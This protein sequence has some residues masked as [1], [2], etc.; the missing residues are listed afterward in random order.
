MWILRRSHGD[1]RGAVDRGHNLPGSRVLEPDSKRVSY[2]QR[3]MDQPLYEL[4]RDRR[5]AVL[6]ALPEA[7]SHRS[8]N[9]LAAHVRTNHVHAIV[10]GEA[11]PERIMNDFKSYDSRRLSRLNPEEGERKR[12]ARHGST[13]WLFEKRAGIGSHSLRGR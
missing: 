5:S 13:R 8:W 12:W 11:P 9:L 10:E 4:D 7:R 1:E 2:E 3:L 6:G